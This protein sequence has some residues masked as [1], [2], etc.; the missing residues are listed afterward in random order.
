MSS[1]A[2]VGPSRVHGVGV[3]AISDIEAGN[4]VLRIDD[5]RVV[6]VAHPLRSDAGEYE[7]HCDYLAGG[8]VVLMASPERH[9]NHS[10]SPNTYVKTIGQSRY[11]FALRKIIAGEEITYDYC[12]NSAG[13]TVWE[14]H[15]G[16]PDCRRSIHSDFF[17]LPLPRQLAYL[18]LLDTWYL[19]EHGNA[20]SELLAAGGV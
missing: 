18:P 8:K 9:I 10:C 2:I 7:F 5:S 1:K 11:V 13:D 16:A 17:H 6:D 3:F 12:L 14:C 19:E 15:C 20:V 4:P